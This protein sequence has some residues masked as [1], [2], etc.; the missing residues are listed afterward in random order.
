MRSNVN[1]NIQHV[2][3][4][5]EGNLT[6][7]VHEAIAQ[8]LFDNG[9]RT[10]FGLIGDGNLFL[11]DSFTRLGQCQYVAAAH[12]SGAVLMALGFAQVA[13]EIGVATVTH[14]PAL[15]N[16]L[17]ALTEGVKARVP[18]VLVCGDTAV[19]ARDHLQ[20]IPQR[21]LVVATGAGFEILRSA[22]TLTIDVANAF[23]RAL[24]ERRPIVLN[25]PIEI[26]WQ[27]I[28]YTPNPF[29]RF[30]T[31]AFV[32]SGAD[33][34][35]GVGI[36]AGAKRPVIIAG[37]G[38]TSPAAKS[39]I[40]RLA[41]RIGAPL[42]TTL[43]AKNLFKNEP[44]DLGIFGTLAAPVAF[45]IIAESDCIIAFGASLNLYTTAQQSLVKGKRLV[46]I[47]QE[48]EEIGKFIT[49]DA[50]IVGDAAEVAQFIMRLLDEAEISTSD[51]CDQD[52]IRRIGTHAKS[53][54]VDQSTTQTIDIVKALAHFEISVPKDRVFVTDGGRFVG[55]AWNAFSVESPRSFLLTVNFGSIGLG[56]SEAIGASFAKKGS[57]TLLVTGDG[58]F[59]NGG[60]VEFNTAVRARAD[61][62]VLL[63]N[64]SSYGAEHIQFTSRSLNPEISMFAWPEFA[65]VAIALG[66]SGVTVRTEQDLKLADHAIRNRDRPLLIDIKLDAYRV[67][68]TPH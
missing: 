4:F 25:V 3:G 50:G 11:V 21:E 41:R 54:W 53:D 33:V 64:D 37:R 9:V 67:P 68:V 38:A 19:E 66:G 61:L 8:A 46:Q 42:A 16:T 6:M 55:A 28:S 49:P 7:K 65:D 35:N 59:M 51:F 12:E 58:G 60:L 34:D 56:M 13:D 24:V 57:P 5:L 2:E 63:C 43:K 10:L 22:K 15:V 52:M 44:G 26:Q 18:L 47:N 39:A 20:K 45:E 1:I 32:M 30:D 40:L 27:D 31:R 36:I 23:R 62:I 29:R 14:G 48:P 17:T